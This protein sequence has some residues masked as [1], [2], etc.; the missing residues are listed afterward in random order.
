MNP[1]YGCDDTN[2]GIS[3]E[4]KHIIFWLKKLVIHFH[5]WTKT[6]ALEVVYYT[7]LILPHLFTNIL[8]DYYTQETG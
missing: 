2:I 4:L 5:L 6:L 1:K 7:W 8:L 3:V